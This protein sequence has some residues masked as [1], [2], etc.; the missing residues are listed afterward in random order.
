MRKFEN[1]S[2]SSNDARELSITKLIQI[3]GIARK[4]A[5]AMYEIGI[6][7][8]ADLI[9]HLEHHTA[10]ELSEAFREHN[11]N[12]PPGLIDTETWIRQAKMLSQSEKTIFPPPKEEVMTTMKPTEQL[13]DHEPREHHA[14]F[15]VSFDI[16][17]DDSD[18]QS[19]YITVYDE[20]DGGEEKVFPGTDSS[21]WVNWILERANL[22][23]IMNPIH[24]RVEATK[25]PSSVEI[26]AAV[27]SIPEELYD[28]LLEISDVQFSKIRPTSRSSEKRLRAGID[29]KLSGSDAEKLTLQ[30]S[31]FRIEVYTIE[32]DNGFPRRILI[33]EDQF[34]PHLFGYSYQLDFA[35]PGVGRYEFH[36][37]VRLLPSG[38]LRGYHRGPTLRITP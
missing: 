13:S 23:F 8:Y 10:E 35:M 34:K 14:V 20:R 36:S 12:R 27:Q 7:S 5:E 26:Q 11:V 38:E 28:I 30:S 29:I 19:L 4:T 2:A 15:T 1:G 37:L 24:S 3:N 6:H 9:E 25:E 31:P 21:S 18:D 32:L 17:N 22:P 16:P 33:S